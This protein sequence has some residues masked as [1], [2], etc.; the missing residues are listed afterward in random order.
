[1]YS[2]RKGEQPERATFHHWVREEIAAE[3]DEKGA[4]KD[5]PECSRD[6]GAG[7]GDRTCF[8]IKQWGW[9]KTRPHYPNITMEYERRSQRHPTKVITDMRFRGLLVISRRLR[10][11]RE[12]DTV[13]KVLSSAYEGMYLEASV[14]HDSRLEIGDFTDRM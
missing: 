9:G 2:R 13:P 11:V 3:E 1:M 7:P 5:D 4:Y 12:F 6:V 8:C 14:R 10:P